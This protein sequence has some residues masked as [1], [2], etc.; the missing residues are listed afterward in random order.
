MRVGLRIK[1]DDDSAMEAGWIFAQKRREVLAIDSEDHTIVGICA[2]RNEIP[3]TRN[4]KY[5][6][7]IENVRID[8]Y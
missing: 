6:R 7:D 5:F 3:I 1:L 2:R 4:I 8:D